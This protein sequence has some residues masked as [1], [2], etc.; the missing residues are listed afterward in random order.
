M[1]DTQHWFCLNDVRGSLRRPSP[2]I[3]RRR[4]GDLKEN[5]CNENPVQSGLDRNA[6]KRSTLHNLTVVEPVQTRVF[7]F[8]GAQMKI[9]MLKTLSSDLG[10]FA[11]VT[12]TPLFKVANPRYPH[13]KV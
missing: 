12:F 13:M 9:N 8:G 4:C 5:K 1:F 6:L 2:Y 11:M 7:F 10:C 3:H